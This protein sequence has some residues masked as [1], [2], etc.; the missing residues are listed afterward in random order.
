MKFLLISPPYK[1]G[2]RTLIPEGMAIT[3][4]LLIRN[5]SVKQIDLFMRVREWNKKHKGKN[6]I[7]LNLFNNPKTIEKY[8]L[9][10]KHNKKF[11]RELIK[12]IKIIKP[13]KNYIISFSIH[14]SSQL[15]FALIISKMI[16][17]MYGNK[18][19]FGGAYF[20][21]KNRYIFNNFKWV[22]IVVSG[23]INK[24]YNKIISSLK[25]GKRTLIINKKFDTNLSL[26]PDYSDIN[27]NDYKYKFGK[28]YVKFLTTQTSQ[29]CPFR[30]NFCN[31]YKVNPFIVYDPKRVVRNI[32]KL[33]K[34]Y[35]IDHFIFTNQLINADYRKISELCKL[36]IKSNLKIEWISYARPDNLDENLIS[37]MSKSGCLL[38]LFGLESAS[39]RVQRLMNKNINIKH[40][41]KLLPI[42]KKH[43]IQ[44]ALNLIINYPGENE[45]DFNKT[46]E[47]I[48]EYADY[49]DDVA[50]IR[51][52]VLHKSNLFE[53]GNNQIK[54]SKETSLLDNLVCEYQ[55]FSDKIPLKEQK[56]RLHK[57]LKC[58]YQHI[59]RKKYPFFR[60]IPFL[61]FDLLYNKNLLFGNT[62]IYRLFTFICKFIPLDREFKK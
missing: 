10:D 30:C 7:D 46:L 45:K 14:C 9:K 23:Y 15:V 33:K 38:L 17:R 22:D 32:T 6:Y 35:S 62:R 61:F 36:I 60:L 3:K 42:L 34:R 52:R 47:F 40:F 1:L 51:I 24:T 59:I 58:I 4:S 31:S 27:L 5:H 28:K 48:K 53:C 41:K 12:I 29:G 11:D 26:I 54:I 39:Q 56:R 50:P 55:F 18:I 43:N 20:F 16:K 37:L 44:V 57:I 49:L 2:I 25:K 19:L 8:L 21:I 13:K